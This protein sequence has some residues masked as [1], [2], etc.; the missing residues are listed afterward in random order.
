MHRVLAQHECCRNLGVRP[1]R[2]DETQDLQFAWTELRAPARLTARL[3][4]TGMTLL[5]RRAK[6]EK[7]SA[8][9]VELRPAASFRPWARNEQARATR[10]RAASNGRPARASSPTASSNASRASSWRR[11]AE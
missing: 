5:G 9:S 4:L 7:R 3:K 10:A 1:A 6:V 11:A 8:C 2:R